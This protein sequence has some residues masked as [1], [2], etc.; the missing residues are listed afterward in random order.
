MEQHKYLKRLAPQYYRGR[1]YVHW[2]LAIE[3]RKTGWLNPVLHYNY[4]EI[5]SHTMFRYGLCCPIYC[6]M[7]E[8]LHLLWV[9][10]C[11]WSDQRIAMRFFRQHMKPILERMGVRFQ[12]QPYDHVLREEER[13]RGAFEKVAGYIARNPERRGLVPLDGYADYPYTGCLIPGYPHLV[14][15]EHRY[16]EKFWRIYSKLV[17]N[18]FYG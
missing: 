11:E 14:P 13:E 16:W 6:C 8:H 5:L 17:S 3:D 1:A 4:R 2:S 18:G 7:P 12:K 10:I 9:G 15:F